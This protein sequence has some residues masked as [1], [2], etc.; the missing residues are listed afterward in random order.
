[1]YSVFDLFENGPR[2]DWSVDLKPIF[3]PRPRANVTQAARATSAPSLPLERYA[4]TYVDSAYGDV[5]VT[6][7]NGA[8]QAAVVTDPAAPLEPVSFEAFRTKP[9][10]SGRPTVL[11][12]V[13]DGNGGVS[14]VRVFNIV[15]ARVRAQPGG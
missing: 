2:R 6:L 10:G 13:P 11:T 15:F 7:E 3:A 9:N 12:F 4:G 14:G 1:M 8:L 5:H